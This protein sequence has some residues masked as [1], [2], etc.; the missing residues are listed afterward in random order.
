MASFSSLWVR[1]GAYSKVEHL[2]EKN[3]KAWT[4]IRKLQTKRFITKAPNGSLF[5]EKHILQG[6]AETI[7]RMTLRMITPLNFTA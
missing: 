3:T 7:S 5:D 1:P 4:K 2:K 6:G